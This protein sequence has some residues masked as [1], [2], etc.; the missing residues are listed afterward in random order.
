VVSLDPGGIIWRKEVGK[1]EKFHVIFLAW[2]KERSWV[3]KTNLQNLE[4]D[5]T[6]DNRKKEF[7]VARNKGALYRKHLDAIKLACNIL[8]DPENP[9]KYFV[10][11]EIQ[12]SPDGEENIVKNCSVKKT[13]SKAN[14][15]GR[16]KQKLKKKVRDLQNKNKG[17]GSK[18]GYKF[19]GAKAK[20]MKRI[21]N[22]VVF[23]VDD[24]DSQNNN[25]V[26][27]K[28]LIKED[29]EEP[30][31]CLCIGCRRDD[32][33]VCIF[34]QDKVKY[35]GRGTL[36]QPCVEKRCVS[37]RLVEKAV[38]FTSSRNESSLQGKGT[39]QFSPEINVD[40]EMDDSDDSVLDLV[41]DEECLELDVPTS[42]VIS[43]PPR[44]CTSPSYKAD[45]S[46][47][48][49]ILPKSLKF[50]KNNDLAEYLDMGQ[51][52]GRDKGGSLK[53]VQIPDVFLMHRTVKIQEDGNEMIITDAKTGEFLAKKILL[54]KS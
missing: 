2:N 54:S 40:E 53:L 19:E 10:V 49:L 35:G 42:S 9:E 4:R 8:E 18:I 41:I 33:G 52:F 13:A 37:G 24:V 50:R 5:D 30:V 48:F 3:D 29:V 44:S 31:R 34:C 6:S 27:V 45:D 1:S 23:D 28:T 12:S 46:E 20:V 7:I 36:M 17:V 14:P 11:E 32:C 26:L 38:S 39:F 25:R 43:Y 15:R 47:D 21:Q 22:Q 16:P 51:L